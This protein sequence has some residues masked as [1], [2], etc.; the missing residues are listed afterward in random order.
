MYY[1]RPYNRDKLYY[2]DKLMVIQ[3]YFRKFLINRIQVLS[4]YY[5]PN[6][7]ILYY[8]AANSNFLPL[9]IELF[10][11][12]TW[13]IYEDFELSYQLFENSK[14]IF[15]Y[16][17]KLTAETAKTWKGK[18]DVFISDYRRPITENTISLKDIETPLQEKIDKIMLEDVFINIHLIKI[19]I[20][21]LGAAIKLKIPFVDPSSK[22]TIEVIKGSILWLPWSSQH[23]TDGTLVMDHKEILHNTNMVMYLSI[24]QN[25]YSTHNRYYRPWGYYSIPNKLQIDTNKINGF[26]HCFDCV[27]ELS[28]LFNYFQTV[29][30]PQHL[31]NEEPQHL[32]NGEKIINLMNR[33]S[34][35]FEPLISIKNKLNYHGR[36]PNILPAIRI[37]NISQFVNIGI[38]A[39]INTIKKSE[40]L[41]Q[42]KDAANKYDEF[43]VDVES[44]VE[45]HVERHD[46]RHVERHDE[47]HNERHDEKFL[48]NF[49]K[50]INIANKLIN[51]RFKNLYQQKEVKLIINGSGRLHPLPSIWNDLKN[52]IEYRENKDHLAHNL[53]YCHLGQR[54]L[55]MAE[56]ELL[57][58]F[59]NDTR[60]EITI[61]YAGAAA[62]YHLPL[63]FELFPNTTWHLYDPAPFCTA[64]LKMNTEK[65]RVHL[66]NE[67]FTDYTAIQWENKCDIF[68]CDIRLM[69]NDRNVF[70]T[71]VE[72]DMRSQ[73][74]W[75]L[76]IKPKLCASLK[77]RPP[78]L[79]SK[80]K[81]YE[82]Q[83]IRGKIM[84]QMWPPRN[85]T[86][87]RLIID[88]KDLTSSNPYMKLDVVKYQNACA[89][90]N[91]IERAWLAYELPAGCETANL[92]DGYDRC[93]DCT[94]EAI[95]WTHYKKLKNAKQLPL[96]VYMDK[97]TNITHQK[98]K[99][100]KNFHGNNQYELPAIR[101]MQL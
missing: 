73:E 84:W 89:Y 43:F 50:N 36:L 53:V 32:K 64:L 51:T 30:E 9:L 39:N 5:K 27:C 58:L 97:L 81:K 13:H 85:S 69:A 90:H 60:D 37:D 92:V 18:V 95:C 11:T 45:R 55:F 26:C 98:L 6:S 100:K 28:T 56:L 96:N 22:Q 54:K 41:Q 74:K 15:L 86:E 34:Y 82:Y 20:P 42:L 80:I 24:L 38:Y 63:L 46:E 91:L 77:F 44:H 76:T 94:C 3:C 72:A 65:K 47:R 49:E 52:I 101:L 21:N 67:F 70:E 31:K 75:T 79:E 68:I 66:Y 99:N 7:V 25:A 61:L 33:L 14:N 29:T 48:L 88:S 19:I 87:C 59:L 17:E 35:T 57:N 62:G 83:Y 16:K 12:Y 93:F 4:K 78:Y 2:P 8:G 1:I 71:Q 40:Y 10:P 23:S